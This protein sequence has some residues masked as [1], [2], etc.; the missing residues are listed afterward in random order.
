MNWPILGAI[1]VGL[2]LSM[3][4]INVLTT[5][6]LENLLNRQLIVYLII[7]VALI[8]AVLINYLNIL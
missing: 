5:L 7:H 1:Y 6:N 8:I 4:V 3:T 2:L